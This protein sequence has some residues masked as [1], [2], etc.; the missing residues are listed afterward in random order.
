MDFSPVTKEELEMMLDLLA[1]E[2]LPETE[3]VRDLKAIGDLYGIDA[4]AL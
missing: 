2:P 3:L 1:V 4:E